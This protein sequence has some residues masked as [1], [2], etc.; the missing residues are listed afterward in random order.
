MVNKDLQKDIPSRI[1]LLTASTPVLITPCLS[2]LQAHSS[3]CVSSSLSHFPHLHPCHCLLTSSLFYSILISSHL[4]SLPHILPTTD[5]WYPSDCLSTIR[6]PLPDF[7]KIGF[8]VR[9]VS[10]IFSERYVENAP[11]L[12]SHFHL[13]VCPSVTRVN[14]E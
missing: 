5:N 10:L 12:R 2:L 9:H 4:L 1:N 14:C 7:L 13:S 8:V 3:A 6:G 11:L